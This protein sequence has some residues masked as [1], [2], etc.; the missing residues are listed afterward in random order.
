MY[1]YVAACHLFVVRLNGLAGLSELP[2]L[3]GLAGLTGLASLVSVAGLHW[4]A[5][6]L[7][8]HS[9]ATATAK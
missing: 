3:L 1:V 4:P 6:G 5:G 9:R 8:S 2:E 7:H